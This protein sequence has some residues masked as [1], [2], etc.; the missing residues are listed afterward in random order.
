MGPTKLMAMYTHVGGAPRQRGFC[1]TRQRQTQTMR[2][3]STSGPRP[4]HAMSSALSPQ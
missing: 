4:L 3:S 1:E 2:M